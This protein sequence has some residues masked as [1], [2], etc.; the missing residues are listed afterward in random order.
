MIIATLCSTDGSEP[1]A[2]NVPFE[3]NGSNW[4]TKLSKKYA[5]FQNLTINPNA[6]I[7]C[8][9][10]NAELLMK[11]R[12]EKKSE[13]EVSSVMNFNVYWL[14]VATK[15]DTEDF[16]DKAKIATEIGKYI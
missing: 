4:T 12:A 2:A 9:T 3:A 7:V 15:E 8:Q 1:W 5:H 13:D 10:K 6:V 16:D 11:A 14:R